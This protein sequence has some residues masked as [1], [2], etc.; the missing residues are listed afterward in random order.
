MVNIKQ[1]N[2]LI[3]Y[4]TDRKPIFL[5]VFTFSQADGIVFQ[6]TA[7]GVITTAHCGTPPEPSVVNAG[8]RTKV[9]EAASRKS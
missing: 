5:E 4:T 9:A 3:P 2:C 8:E 1:P 7:P 6:A